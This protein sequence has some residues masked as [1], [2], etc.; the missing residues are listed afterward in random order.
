MIHRDRRTVW[1]V[2]PL[3]PGTLPRLST[4]MAPRRRAIS[5]APLV[6]VLACRPAPPA[7]DSTKTVTPEAPVATR[8]SE[9]LVLAPASASAT[10]SAA[11][12]SVTSAL[13]GADRYPWLG[14][15]SC[16]GPP[17]VS[18]LEARFPAPEGFTRVPLE[19][20]SFGAFLRTLPMA[21]PDAAVLTYQKRWGNFRAALRWSLQ[22]MKGGDSTERPPP[23]WVP[24]GAIIATAVPLAMFTDW[25]GWFE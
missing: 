20:A 6:L 22:S 23:T 11:P 24:L 9:P 4:I 25:I 7:G 18:T 5:L 10:P 16:A 12:A 1:R 14:D 8:R 3:V 13:P 17:V 15:K 19:P 2:N 21:P